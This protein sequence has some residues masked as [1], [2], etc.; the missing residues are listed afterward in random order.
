VADRDAVVDAY[1]RAVAFGAPVEKPPR[2]TWMGARLHELSLK[3]AGGTL[4]EIYA[5]LMDD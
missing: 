1:H 2:A 5:W 4:I 3:D